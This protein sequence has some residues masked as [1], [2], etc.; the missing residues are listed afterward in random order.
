MP[1]EKSKRGMKK[2]KP[3]SRRMIFEPGEAHIP[4]RP[5]DKGDLSILPNQNSAR[6]NCFCFAIALLA[7][8]G[9]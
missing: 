9:T 5:L 1:K 4:L 2:E 3:G 7:S 6:I 8:N